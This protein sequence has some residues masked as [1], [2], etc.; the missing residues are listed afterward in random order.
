MLTSF[1]H[2][3]DACSFDELESRLV[4]VEASLRTADRHI[5]NLNHGLN[6]LV[7]QMHVL[8]R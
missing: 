2:S 6:K 7:Q 5:S 8:T 1:A 3:L 4:E